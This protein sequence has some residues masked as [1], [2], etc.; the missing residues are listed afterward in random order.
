MNVFA[1]VVAGTSWLAASRILSIVAVFISFAAISRTLGPDA[2]GQ[3]NYVLA[4]AAIMA[5]IGQFGLNAIVVRDLVKSPDATGVILGSTI[6]I[7]FA[8]TLAAL[9]LAAA[10]IAYLRPDEPG[11]QGYVIILMAAEIAKAW[12]ACS[13]VFEANRKFSLIAIASACLTVLFAVAK[14]VFAY[15]GAGI[16][17]FVWLFAVEGAMIGPLFY[18]LFRRQ[19]REHRLGVSRPQARSLVNRSGYLAVSGVLALIN[20]KLDMI[21]L[22][23]LAGDT[24]TGVYAAAVRIS[25]LWYFLPGIIATAVFPSL[26]DLQKKDPSAFQS[27]FQNTLDALAAL[28]F[29][30][31]LVLSLFAGPIVYVAF[32]PEYAPAATVIVIH[33]WGGLF[34]AVRAM[35]SKWLVAYDLYAMSL[36][37]HGLGA[38][39]NFGLNLLLIPL[40]GANGAA[41]ATIL[42][43][44]VSGYLVFFLH[45]RTRPAA[46]QITRAL[47]VPLRL[48]WIAPDLLE[49]VQ[50]ARNLPVRQNKRP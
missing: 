49:Q 39:A 31:I 41:V 8:A 17:S 29:A 4:I 50:A 7:R 35:A 9:A 46:I 13:F 21:M 34:V 11:L 6:A 44:A 25:E 15:Y 23:D 48:P 12:S 19:Y 26:L 42:S 37:S 36:V 47:L 43:Y 40:W 32:G 33:A 20:L 27:V 1:S 16:S 30:V 24:A 14:L 18:V 28:A 5:P 10:L 45:K 2:F 38:G 3:L 22:G